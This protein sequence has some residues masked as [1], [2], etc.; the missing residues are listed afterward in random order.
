MD[1]I[2]I[3]NVAEANVEDLCRVCLPQDEHD[4]DWMIGVEEKKQW[5]A[6]MLPR[7]GSFAKVAYQGADPVGMMQYRPIPEERIVY[8][9]CIYVPPA[10]GLRKGIATRLFSALMSDVR[11][12]MA[13][14]DDERPLALVVNTF[15]GG[16]H[17]QYTAR[18]FFTGKGFRQVG[19]DPDHLYY[20]LQP[21]FVYRPIDKRD[22]ECIRRSEDMGRVLIIRGPNGCPATYPF[23]LK[24]ME[25]YIREID[26][27]VP[28]RWIDS[29]QE[30]GELSKRNAR[31]GDCIVNA[32]LVKCFVLDKESFQ[33]EVQALLKVG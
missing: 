27:E 30:P 29:S 3:E 24:K 31:V 26:P 33:K 13:W 16:A 6:E 28:I 4:P 15:E 9:D 1:E 14:F 18:E 19:E 12:P 22:A 7:W 10:K 25:K 2:R 17:G 20:P 5:A 11:K 21:G 23:F 32:R 8:I